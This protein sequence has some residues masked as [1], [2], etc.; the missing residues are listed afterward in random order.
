MK[1]ILRE[2]MI[3]EKIYQRQLSKIGL[4]DSLVDDKVAL[5]SFTADEVFAILV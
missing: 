3:D 1:F 5:N 2:G 4:S